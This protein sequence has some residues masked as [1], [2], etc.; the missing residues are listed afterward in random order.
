MAAITKQAT[1]IDDKTIDDLADK[2]LDN[3]ELV[4]CGTGFI[5]SLTPHKPMIGLVT[6]G[7]ILGKFLYDEIRKAHEATAPVYTSTIADQQKQWSD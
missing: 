2:F 3:K 4:T 7:V 1:D 5:S 6:G